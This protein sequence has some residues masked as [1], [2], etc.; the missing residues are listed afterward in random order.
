MTIE[1][2]R[3][4]DVAR[5]HRRT[6]GTPQPET[7]RLLERYR[8]AMR[9][10]LEDLLEEI[11]PAPADS[12]QIE[13]GGEIPRA[14]PKLEERRALWDLAIK[15]GREL[16][17][18][19]AEANWTGVLDSTPAAVAGALTCAR[20]GSRGGNASRSA[21]SEA[22]PAAT[23][24]DAAPG[25]R[26]RLVGPARDGVRAPGSSASGSTAGSGGRS[27]GPWPW[28]RTAGSCIASIS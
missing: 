27:R 25:E 2:A 26:R 28:A 22:A 12:G 10:E 18:P 7:E 21:R 24:G 19:M 17:S 8:A 14:R 20:R 4:Q 13:L 9:A 6:R 5:P 23:L 3:P 15:L 1:T 11:R 16:G